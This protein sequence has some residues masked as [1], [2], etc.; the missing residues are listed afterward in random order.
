MSRVAIVG[1]GPCKFQ[2]AVAMTVLFVYSI[3][4]IA[5]FY[6]ALHLLKS[7][8]IKSIDMFEKLP[9]PFGLVR[10][11]I[12]PDHEDAQVIPLSPTT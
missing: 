12:A 2:I 3:N 8:S 11:G 10:Y 1:S 4:S 9:S 5:G 7:K 6:A